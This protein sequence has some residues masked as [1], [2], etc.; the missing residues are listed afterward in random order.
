MVIFVLRCAT[1]D[2]LSCLCI[3]KA[4][5]GEGVGMKIE[6][7]LIRDIL[8]AV[9]K[10]EKPFIPWQKL[11]IKGYT[12]EQIIMHINVMNES[13]YIKLAPSN[14]S[15]RDNPSPV[16][17][18]LKQSGQEFLNSARSETAWQKAKEHVLNASG[19]ITLQAVSMVLNAYIAQG[20]HLGG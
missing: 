11:G 19:T 4:V 7:D 9:E 1:L 20:L 10:S 2:F 16:I 12:K 3:A 17:E 5:N 15:K 6:I 14:F 8:I 18:R 13:G